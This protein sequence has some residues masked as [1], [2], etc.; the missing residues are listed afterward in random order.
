M[1]KISYRIA[2]RSLDATLSA[3]YIKYKVL[4]KN[5]GINYGRE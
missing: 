4:M 1:E 3:L 5:R 2:R